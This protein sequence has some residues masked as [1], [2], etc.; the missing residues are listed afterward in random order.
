MHLK[1]QKNKQ[2]R[3]NVAGGGHE[4]GT[5]WPPTNPS[6][7][8]SFGWILNIL[9]VAY[10]IQHPK[11][12]SNF[13]FSL[14]F[15]IMTRMKNTKT[16]HI[17]RS[18]IGCQVHL[19][20]IFS[21]IFWWKSWADPK[22]NPAEGKSMLIGNSRGQSSVWLP[23]KHDKDHDPQ[24]L[25]Q[26]YGISTVQKQFQ[27]QRSPTNMQHNQL[28]SIKWL[29][30]VQP[31]A[32]S[33][34]WK[35]TC[36]I[37]YRHPLPFR[38]FQR[39]LFPLSSR[40]KQVRSSSLVHSP[41]GPEPDTRSAGLPRSSAWQ[42]EQPWSLSPQFTKSTLLFPLLYSSPG[43]HRAE[44]VGQSRLRGRR[45]GE[46]GSGDGGEERWCALPHKN[47]TQ[48]ER[49]SLEWCWGWTMKV[50]KRGGRVRCAPV[51]PII[52][53]I[54]W[55]GFYLYICI[56]KLVACTWTVTNG[57]KI[58]MASVHLSP[59]CPDPNTFVLQMKF[60]TFAKIRGSKKLK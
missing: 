8:P 23:S 5:V 59:V 15:V 44:L 9:S 45:E 56:I 37:T 55:S 53:Y 3:R 48:D 10:S 25:I 12:E 18:V 60:V 31:A 50:G 32:F 35:Q 57:D 49:E 33:S 22:S 34:P 4:T 46:L 11:N 20:F 30:L 6:L 27:S 16:R 7:R 39:P 52:Q 47:F 38:P 26:F 51:L 40:I 36:N 43:Q 42:R 2:E 21:S 19:C 24:K 54:T 29:L 17:R 1:G 28:A 14:F 13:R 58:S 41:L